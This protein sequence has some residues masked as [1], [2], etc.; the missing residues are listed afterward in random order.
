MPIRA[1]PYEHFLFTQNRLEPQRIG[2]L[3]F[4]FQRMALVHECRF[5][6]SY[7]FCDLRWKRI[8]VD[9]IKALDAN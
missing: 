5:G 6:K 3:Q 8:S 9:L 4:A 2:V 7:A 1:A